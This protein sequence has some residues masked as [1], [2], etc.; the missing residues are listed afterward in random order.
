MPS[1]VFHP[2][3]SKLSLPDRHRFPIDKYLGIRLALADRGVEPTEF[4]EPQAVSVDKL[5][6]VFEPSY[7]DQLVNNELDHKAMRRIGFPWSE[8]L[9]KRTLT[10]VGG[11]LKTAELALEQGKALNLTGGY[12]HAFANFG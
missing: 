11:T 12:H 9:V 2:I 8:Q 6:R 1:L 5:K 3:Y 4:V 7:V 10:A